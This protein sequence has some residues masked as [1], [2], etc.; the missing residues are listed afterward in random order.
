MPIMNNPQSRLTR[1]ATELVYLQRIPII[2]AAAR[3][4]LWLVGIDIP[5]SVVIAPG[6]RLNHPS[7]GLVVHPSTR[8]E[9]G[10]TLFHGVTLGRSDAWRSDSAGGPTGGIIVG[11]GAV[12]GAGAVVLFRQGETVV[13]GDG[14]II[15]ANTVITK[16]VPAGEVW[17]GN[18]ASRVNTR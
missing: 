4:V 9:Q 6:L 18:P 10:V 5:A 13:I 2:G 3:V 11:A 16:D 15:G 14:A 7:V 1:W 12:I 17:I 8:I